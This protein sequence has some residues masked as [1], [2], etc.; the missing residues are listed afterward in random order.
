MMARFELTD[1]SGSREVVAF[2]RV[3][4]EVA[5]Q[6]EDDAP[7]VLV[8]EVSQEDEAVRLVAERV[9]RWDARDGI[10]EVAVMQFDP[11]DVGQQQLLELRSL[12]DET[13]GATPVQLR[14]PAG[15]GVVTWAVEGVR[16]DVDKLDVLEQHCPWLTTRV[17][18][19]RARLLAAERPASWARRGGES[20]EGSSASPS[21]VD[22]PF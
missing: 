17:T 15:R 13:A 3:F 18:V 7:V 19:D 12:M 14:F 21:R 11:G 16:V 9:I 8:A 4:D 6:L 5:S 20:R 2:S 10:P 22:V 1:A